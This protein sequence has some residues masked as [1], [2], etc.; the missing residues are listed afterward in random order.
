MLVDGAH[1][2]EVDEPDAAIRLDEEVARVGIGMEE[3]VVE[4]HLEQDARRPLGEGGAV[5]ARFVQ[6]AE[7]V[8][9]DSADPL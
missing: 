8:D 7:V 3:A 6:R 4:H 1:H 9:F 2:A 5:D